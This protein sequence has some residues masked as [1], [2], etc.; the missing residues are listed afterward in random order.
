MKHREGS[1]A[2]A[3]TAMCLLP[4]SALLAIGSLATRTM[5]GQSMSTTT[6]QG[7]VYLA[8]GKPGTG[9]LVLRW[10]AF[11]TSAGQAVAA[12]SMTVQVPADGFVS[13]NL[14]P[15][16]GSTPAGE[17]YTAVYDLSDGSTS[18]EYW[19][20]P[21]AASATLAQVRAQV[22]PAA[23]AVQAV[24]KA[25]VD[26]AVAQISQ[27]LLTGAGGNM[28]G[29][30][31]LSGDPTQS[32]QAADKHYVDTAVSAAGQQGSLPLAG[33][34]LSGSLNG[35]NATFSGAFAAIGS[36]SGPGTGLSGTATGLTAG[37]AQNLAA[38]FASQSAASP[39]AGTFT[40][41]T[42]SHTVLP[43]WDDVR[44][45]GAKCDGNT[46]DSTAIQNAINGAG[47]GIVNFPENAICIAEGLTGQT[48]TQLY[49]HGSTLRL[50]T[51]GGTI[52]TF[53]F[54][55]GAN[56][57]SPLRPKII[58]GTFD[59]NHLT[60]S[61]VG[62]FVGN[63]DF[64]TSNV[65]AENCDAGVRID[66]GQYGQ[67]LK[68]RVS[69]NNVGLKL[70]GNPSTGGGVDNSFY[71]FV[72]FANKVGVLSW[73]ESAYG[74][75][76]NNFY[77]PRIAGNTITGTAVFGTGSESTITYYNGYSEAD[78]EPVGG[79]QPSAITVDGLTIQPASIYGSQ[80]ANINLFNYGGDAGPLYNIL[81]NNNS[82]AV[83]DGGDGTA[84]IWN[85][86]TDATS[87]VD[88]S[89]DAFLG[90]IYTNIASWPN[91]VA[92]L[93]TFASLTG[94][95]TNT[96]DNT[97]P[98][99]YTGNPY[100]LNLYTNGVSSAATTNDAQMGPVFTVSHAASVGSY[101]SN[102]T[103]L[104][105]PPYP[106]STSQDYIVSV[107]IKA[108]RN[109]T[110]TLFTE[111]GQPNLI[112]LS[113]QN[114]PLIANQWTRMV[115]LVNLPALT[116]TG[117]LGALFG[118]PADASGP[119]VSFTHL[120]VALLPAGIATTRNIEARMIH[121]GAFNPGGYTYGFNPSTGAVNW[122]LDPTGML[123]ASAESVT[124]NAQIGGTM[125]ANVA[126][127]Q[128]VKIQQTGAS[129]YWTLNEAGGT[130]WNDL[131]FSY[132]GSASYPVVQ[133]PHLNVSSL[134]IQSSS[135]YSKAALATDSVGDVIAAAIHGNSTNVQASDGTGTSGN[136][137]KFDANGNV[138]NGPTPPVGAMVGT[139]DTQTLTNKTVDGVSPTT[140]SY[141]DATSSI[142][143]Q[144]NGKQSALTNPVTGPGSGATVGHMAGCN[145]TACTQIADIGP[146]PTGG[147][148]IPGLS[149]DGSNGI[150]ATGSVQA[151]A[152]IGAGS[153]AAATMLDIYGNGTTNRLSFWNG[154]GS[155]TPNLVLSLSGGKATGLMAGTTGSEFIFDNSGFFV[156]GGDSHANIVNG[157]SSGG[158]QY[159]WVYPSGGAHLGTSSHD[160]G[161]GIFDAYG[162]SLNGVNISFPTGSIVGTT[163]TQTLTNKT[164]DGVSPTAMGYVDAT[165]SIQT[166]LNG[167]AGTST[168]V[169]GHALSS[170][171]KVSASDLTTGTLPHAQLP[172]LI[173]GDI[174]NNAANTTGTAANLSGTPALSNGTAATTQSAGD[175]STKIATTAYVA[176]PGAITPTTVTASGIISGANDT[177]RTTTTTMT[178]AWTTTG[179]VLPTVPVSTIKG[180]R[181][182]IYWQMSSTS[183]TATFGLGMNNAPTNVWGGSQLTYAAT[184]TS[185]WLAFTQSTTT[186]TA[187]STA[188]TAG[189]TG[190][191][192]KA[193]IDFAIQ[194]GGSNSVA[195]TLY[196]ETSNSGATLTIEPGSTC[197]WLP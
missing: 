66:G 13:V 31:Y 168:T 105:Q 196:G 155:S 6:V 110:Y 134:N 91:G 133:L 102:Y 117:A 24:N 179:L 50:G 185:N 35:T 164:V 113:A 104:W 86:N 10:P 36:I 124:G 122:L 93:G 88:M 14:A 184:G 37:H 137:A 156:I 182:V 174:P 180:G 175:N 61:T 72:A 73:S 177:T 103:L 78:S 95:P 183:Y 97:I 25:Y 62:L 172:A 15:N 19:V 41:V 149:S 114:I 119:V 23:Q 143:T 52:L 18:T 158:T 49:M 55:N 150:N 67:Y 12:D 186:T 191:T 154:A 40:G 33:G 27:S 140:M 53:S 75:G 64:Y 58:D 194:T 54:T 8:N 76:N 115:L 29:P 87:R 126:T 145:N 159:L 192:Y 162:Y 32:L 139:T 96:P 197:Y 127:V 68:L 160:P 69:G 129:D 16:Q 141:L 34:T 188:T 130:G 163:D 147:G 7:T 116:G 1:R 195:M 22:M 89:G 136:L 131:D 83:I 190:T 106:G 107:L 28:S 152:N 157:T 74:Q 138:A 81:L 59:C 90:G 44:Y 167:K 178:N 132:T 135:L 20:V 5:Q 118:Y 165:S 84:S 2:I 121:D 38:D 3:R 46:D 85:V 70:Y 71:D 92:G 48:Y 65:I 161:A 82:V 109:C 43:L 142:Q 4:L 193:E 63:A 120:D 181:C 26:Q 187:I 79:V 56:I 77:S 151:G 39:A 47:N 45:Y 108:D 176:S 153:T 148:T 170:N 17:Y 21:A 57:A 94:V 42:A 166:Q 30:L 112:F 171:L 144:L 80:N 128:N 173:S 100:Q 51:A 9:T 60:G 123:T 98:N 111:T 189:A 101:T 169:N 125:T 99:L 11:A 146:V